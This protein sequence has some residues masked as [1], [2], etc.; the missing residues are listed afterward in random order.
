MQVYGENEK[1]RILMSH[2]LYI[3]RELKSMKI[4]SFHVTISIVFVISRNCK[5]GEFLVRLTETIIIF[6]VLKTKTFCLRVL[7][8][9]Y[10]QHKHVKY[11]RLTH[12][13]QLILFYYEMYIII[14]LFCYQP[15]NVSKQ[16]TKDKHLKYKLFFIF[17]TTLYIDT[18]EC[19][20]IHVHGVSAK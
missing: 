15:I 18:F 12:H 4:K 17:I 3:P 7:K 6:L 10:I 16:I 8:N 5:L 2:D 9:I 19:L 1:R 14:L 20:L 13:E 11:M